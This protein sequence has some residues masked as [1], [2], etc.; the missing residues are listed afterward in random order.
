MKRQWIASLLVLVAL[1]AAIAAPAQVA[2]ISI[3]AGT[4][5]DKDLQAVT[6]EN[7]GQKRI[8]M[9]QDYLQKYSGNPQAVILGQWQLA[10]QYLEQGD[11][12]KALEYGQKAVTG[13]PNNLDI[14]VFV[15]GAAQKAKAA[16]V[17]MDCA[18]KGGKAFNG[19]ASQA[20]PEG[21][22]PEAFALKVKQEQE[23]PR[24]N[25]E[26]LEAS[27]LNAMVGEQNAKKRMG[28]I[29]RY[30]AAFPGS[31]FQDQA[32]ELAVSTLGELKDSARMKSFSD[33][34]LAANPNSVSL[35]VVLSDA[36]GRSTDPTTGPLAE[37][38]ARKALDLAKTQTPTSENRLALYVGLAHNALGFAL[39]K[40]DKNLPAITELK[41]ACDQLKTYPEGYPSALYNLGY[42]YAK[43]GKL[44]D[45]KVVLTEL[46]A[47]AG[48]YQQPGRDL[49]AKVQAGPPR[50][51]PKRTK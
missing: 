32:T 24:S 8:A 7:D 34:A 28:Y 6:V 21:M 30:F 41:T 16:D 42:A 51:T 27:A 26:Y 18:E 5:E 25:Y 4:P 20:K 40:Q 29:E 19:I 2:T 9:L 33:K 12:A 49:L 1:V 36:Y 47:I 46:V 31:R 3:A 37:S 45:A 39:L 48:P 15:V 10:Q 17:I 38:Y 35:L 50:P 13:Q 43:T 44:Q 22:D 23:A 14:L 11:T